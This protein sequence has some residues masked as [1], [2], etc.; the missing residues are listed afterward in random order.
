M[1]NNWGLWRGSRLS[2]YFNSLGIFHPD[3]MSGIILTGYCRQLNGLDIRLSDQIKQYQKY[4]KVVR[5]PS[6]RDYPIDA[7]NLKF[8]SGFYYD[9]KGSGQGFIHVGTSKRTKTI[10]IFDHYLGWLNIDDCQLQT[11]DSPST[12]EVNL[13]KLYLLKK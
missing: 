5:E 13:Q 3:D 8:N 2:K 10:W 7:P 1:R 12:R 6:K 4:W 11:L 9:T